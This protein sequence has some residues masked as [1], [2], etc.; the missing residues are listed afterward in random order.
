MR[1]N[2]IARWGAA[3]ALVV[4]LSGCTMEKPVNPASNSSASATSSSRSLADT[5]AAVA[6][7]PGAGFKAARAWDGTTAYVTATLSV[8]DAFTGD[9]ATL[10]DYSLAQLAS[11][12]EVDRG[13]FVRFSFEAPGQTTETAK[14][15][16]ASLGIDS[17]QYAGGSSLELANRDLDDRYGTWPAAV[18]DLP[19]SFLNLTP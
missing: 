6:K 9:P 7:V 17:E 8:T 14:A 13:R 16:L 15:L 4:L 19:A 5:E 11:Q 18:P 12:D 1:R 10:V 3:A 2:R